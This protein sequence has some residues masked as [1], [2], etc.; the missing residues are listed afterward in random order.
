MFGRREAA[1]GPELKKIG[2]IDHEGAVNRRHA[3]PIAALVADLQAA[4]RILPEDREAAAI[5]M[6]SDTDDL[7]FVHDL[8]RRVVV[9]LQNAHRIMMEGIKEIPLV[10]ERHCKSMQQRRG[11]LLHRG[12]IV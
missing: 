4:K 8:L 9:E 5:T 3:H 7:G 10:P 12:E 6:T 1:V 2:D 11:K